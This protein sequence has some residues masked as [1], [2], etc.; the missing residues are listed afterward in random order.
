MIIRP[1]THPGSHERHLL[2][3][4]ANP[5]FEERQAVLDD[6]S[7]MEAQRLD[8]ERLL[9]FLAEFRSLL[10]EAGSLPPNA[11]SEQILG[12]KERLDR[13]YETAAAVADDQSE[14]RQAMVQL[15]N[16]LMTAVRQGAGNDAQAQAEL[17]QEEQARAAHFQL[18]E[19]ALVADLLD[20]QSVITAPELLP[21]LLSVPQEE[22]TLA[23][24]LFDSSQLEILLGQGIQL[25]ERL[26]ETAAEQRRM[27]AQKLQLIQAYLEFLLTQPQTDN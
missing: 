21:T 2:R 11:D 5:L 3:K 25:L 13:A 23:I 24:Q 6:D 22:L 27:A 1:S 7:L 17:D 4:H 14:S 18:L 26:P 10:Q 8:H 16:I 19:A 20:P 9:A 15:L 12:L